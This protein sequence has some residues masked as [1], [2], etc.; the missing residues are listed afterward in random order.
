MPLNE[1]P[2]RAKPSLS[3]WPG[4]WDMSRE[5]IQEFRRQQKLENEQAQ[6]SGDDHGNPERITDCRH[7]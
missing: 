7:Q 5:Q 4:F 2:G 1:S 3:D 6:I